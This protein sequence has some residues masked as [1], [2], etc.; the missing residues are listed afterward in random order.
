M[1][2]ITLNI[3]LSLVVIGL[4]VTLVN[5]H[6]SANVKCTIRIRDKLLEGDY[7]AT[8]LD[9]DS[10]DSFNDIEHPNRV[11]PEETQLTFKKG[12][13]ELSPHSLTIIQVPVRRQ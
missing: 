8:L 6:P 12:V 5:R 13:C 7:N 1:R 10:T 11:A 4:S 2:K 9:G 3:F